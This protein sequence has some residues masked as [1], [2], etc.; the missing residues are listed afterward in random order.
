MP[1]L[2]GMNLK[3]VLRCKLTIEQHYVDTLDF[4]KLMDYYDDISA[5]TEI[6]PKRNYLP[7]DTDRKLIFEHDSNIRLYAAQALDKLRPN[8]WY[9]CYDRDRI[10]GTDDDTYPKIRAE[11]TARKYL[12]F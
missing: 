4:N 3:A 10:F 8:G 2:S 6:L 7:A 11:Y 5:E 12:D 9:K 1:G